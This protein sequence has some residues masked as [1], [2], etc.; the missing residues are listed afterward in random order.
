MPLKPTFSHLA[1]KF[2]PALLLV[3]LMTPASAQTFPEAEKEEI[4]TIVREYLLENPEVITEAL[5][6]LG[7]RQ[8]LAEETARLDAVTNLQDQIFDSPYQ[9]VMGNP[10]GDVTMVEFFDYNC[11]FCKRAHKD[12]LALMD[13]DPG[14]RFVLKEFPVLGQGSVEAARISIAVN[15]L[16]PEKFPEFHLQVLLG[17]G[18]ANAAK[19]IKVA[20]SLGIDPDEL[21]A[22]TKSD[23]AAQTIQEVYMLADGLGLTGT[24]SYVVGSKVLFGAVG[25]QELR[26]SIEAARDEKS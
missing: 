21:E 18:Q 6:A 2:M 16:A 4:R 19:A 11:G 23:L 12:M 9:V 10:D 13:S 17:P 20:T 5:D 15:E 25:E 3:P 1:R 14:L 24:P 7:T 26:D 8:K 22:A